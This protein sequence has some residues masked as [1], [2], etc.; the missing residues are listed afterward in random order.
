MHTPDSLPRNFIQIFQ[1]DNSIYGSYPETT[2][3]ELILLIFQESLLVMHSHYQKY[4]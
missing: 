1:K 3:M 2:H 4:F